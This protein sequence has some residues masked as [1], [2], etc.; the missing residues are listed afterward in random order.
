MLSADP[1]K[2]NVSG[3]LINPG[4]DYE[5]IKFYLQQKNNLPKHIESRITYR[6]SMKQC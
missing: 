1:E 3:E 4:Q 6:M 2:Y 5:K